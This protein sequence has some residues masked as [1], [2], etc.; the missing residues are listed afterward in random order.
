M[1]RSS[2]VLARDVGFYFVVTIAASYVA[3]LC[4]IFSAEELT[5]GLVMGMMAIANTIA[6][7]T[8]LTL[9]AIWAGERMWRHI[10]EVVGVIFLLYTA[11]FILV[12]ETRTG[13][14]S[15]MLLVCS[16]LLP[17]A[18]EGLAAGGIAVLWRFWRSKKDK[19][20]ANTD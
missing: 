8:A 11:F 1:A 14:W 6:G 18:I 17:L 12:L 13:N 7:L 3:Y 19:L 9:I 5:V 20:A 16:A 4:L 10:M 15:D 2:L